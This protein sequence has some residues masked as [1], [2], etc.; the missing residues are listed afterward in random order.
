[1]HKVFLSL[2]FAF[3]FLYW[4][5]LGPTQVPTSGKYARVSV[6]DSLPNAAKWPAEIT[7][8][9]FSSPNITPSPAC[10]AV[11]PTG[12]VF[13]GVDMI[14]SLGKKP[15]QGSIMKLE[16]TDNDG[17]LDRHSTFAM[18]DN[19]R[20]IIAQGHQV[21]VLH[22][23]FGEETG[24]AEGMDLVVF[25]DKNQDGK[26]DGPPKPLIK[27]I[28]SPKFLQSR[29]TDHST[30]GIRMGIDGWIYIA[31]G[32]FGFVDAEDRSGKKLT[33]LGG[34]ILRV[35]PDGTE[36][37]VYTHGLRNI[38]DVAIDPYMN[39]FTRGN[40]ND[41]GGW[42]VR[43]IHQIQSGE[44]GYPVLFKH[45]TEE[46]LPALVDVGGGSGTGALFMDDPTWP[47]KYNHVP[48][49]SDWGRSQLYIHR[50]TPDGPSYTQQEEEFV[51]LAQITDVDIDASGRVYMSAWDGAGYSGNP[52]K[53]FVVR[54]VPNDWK[55]KAFPDVRKLSVNELAVLLKSES[56]VARLAA[57]QE[58][59]TRP[60]SQTTAA[61]W[62]IASDKSNP[63]HVRVAAMY[64][65]AQAAKAD[66]ISNL[67]KLATEPAMREYA[68]RALADRKQFMDKVPL[69]T[70]TQALKDGTP[71][72]QAAAIIGMGRLGRKEAAPAL[73][74]VKVPSSF[75]APTGNIEGPH[76]TPNS[77]I[78]L[79]H[80]AVRAL[81]SLDAVDASV[82]AVGSGNSTLALWA[83]RYMHDPKAVN[84][85]IGAYG[86]A[87][88]KALKTQILSTLAR[89]Y[90]KE[91]PYDG[92]WWWSTRPDTH[93]PYYKTVTWESSPEIKSFLMKEWKNSPD[94]EFYT[95]LND[96]LR[97]D[98]P[99]FGTYEVAGVKEEVKVDLDKIKSRKG[100]VGDAS[101]ED[102]MLAMDDLK[103]DPAQGKKLFTRQGCVACHS[104][105]KGEVMKGPFMGQIGS[106]MNRQQI[107]ESI[108]KP[109]ASISQGF[110]TVMITA[111]GDRTFMG[112]VTEESADQLV[113]R[114]IAGQVSYIKASDIL[115][116]KEMENSMMPEGLANAL[117]YEE[118]ASLITFL[119]QQKK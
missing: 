71:R 2:F 41:G 91:A 8:T 48:M 22:T 63:D 97:L 85:L 18:M 111:K 5:N 86:K 35:R 14:G 88:D 72:V 40:T 53:G 32:D 98:I 42:N 36:M 31:V 70:F 108:L 96:K 9:N 93:G 6:A 47:A 61:A 56:G 87:T 21:F 57:Q 101:I 3:V 92:S 26:A 105:D 113:L 114:D 107:A 11:A 7:I 23:V 77:A 55:Y 19:P 118:F 60:A 62:K 15:G 49:M 1:M 29:G 54:A 115:T 99:E 75:V 39:I 67:A 37:E 81:V 109:N 103:G 44:Y 112:F 82:K 94:K 45:F 102:V 65:Y 117:S 73:L 17:K 95:S 34:G 27:H 79:P 58:M 59:L 74:S 84:G 104:I 76:A 4:N 10:L 52:D 78:V 69:A 30:N 100:Q 25:E 68:L 116:R 119:S 24:I 46:I 38:Y 110:A 20:G 80:L 33:Q 64:T 12:E 51:K 106:I 28:S 83:L 89:L 13:V 66:G 16:D 90:H 43:F 50:V